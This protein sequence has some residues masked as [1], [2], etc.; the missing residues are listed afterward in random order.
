MTLVLR[1]IEDDG[2]VDNS[3]KVTL[4]INIIEDEPDNKKM[5]H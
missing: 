4:S 1:L 5:R 3:T 2:K